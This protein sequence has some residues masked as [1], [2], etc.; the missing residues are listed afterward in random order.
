M[1]LCPPWLPAIRNHRRWRGS[2]KLSKA[3][4]KRLVNQR[5]KHSWP[6]VSGHFS[7]DC[8]FYRQ[9]KPLLNLKVDVQ[10]VYVRL[11]AAVRDFKSL[12]GVTHD[13]C[14]GEAGEAKKDARQ[15]LVD[16]RIECANLRFLEEF[17]E[18]KPF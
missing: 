17:A 5:G 7:F 11:P 4:I 16:W 18:V 14:P 2:G 15:A 12:T 1:A 8:E 3:V 9:G 13:P 10:A 6:L